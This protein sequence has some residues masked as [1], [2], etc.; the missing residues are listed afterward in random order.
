MGIGEAWA[1]GAI[2]AAVLVMF[3]ARAFANVMNQVIGVSYIA[4][5]DV[6]NTYIRKGKRTC[7]GLV[8]VNVRDPL[9]RFEFCVTKSEHEGTAVGDKLQVSGRRSKY[10]NEVLGY[11][12]AQ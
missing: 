3:G 4:K 7:Y 12:T 5:Y 6:V 2:A 8:I 1:T 9:D 11:S 10:V